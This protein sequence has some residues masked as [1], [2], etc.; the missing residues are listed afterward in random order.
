MDADPEKNAAC[1]K[2]IKTP[3]Y[4][5]TMAFNKSQPGICLAG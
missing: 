5:V 1:G 4:I 3:R 2:I